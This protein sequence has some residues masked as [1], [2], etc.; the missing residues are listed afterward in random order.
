MRPQDKKNVVNVIPQECMKIL[1]DAVMEAIRSIDWVT[2][3]EKMADRPTGEWIWD[4]Y[5]SL[6]CTACKEHIYCPEDP[7]IPVETRFC[8]NCGAKMKRH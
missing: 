1:A 4:G 6:Y 8:P 5:T 3:G 2:L 7:D